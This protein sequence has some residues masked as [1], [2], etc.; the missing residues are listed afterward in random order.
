MRMGMSMSIDQALDEILIQEIID[1]FLW[2][3]VGSGEIM[4]FAAGTLPDDHDIWD[5][6]GTDYTPADTTGFRADEGFWALD[7]TDITPLDV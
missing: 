2:E 3:L 7:S 5:L 6:D 1:D 4:P